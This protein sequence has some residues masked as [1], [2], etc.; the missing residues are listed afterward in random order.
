M[1]CSNPF[2][3]R[4]FLS[5]LTYVRTNF[6]QAPT[7]VAGIY[8]LH[9]TLQFILPSQFILFHRQ[10]TKYS[11]LLVLTRKS[12]PINQDGPHQEP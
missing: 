3:E 2:T 7:N 4:F 5:L 6:Q 1:L 8:L 9:S 11:T 10:T 12:N